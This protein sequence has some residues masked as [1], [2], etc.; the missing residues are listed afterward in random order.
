M[1]DERPAKDQVL[2][3]DEKPQKEQLLK[4]IATS[5]IKFPHIILFNCINSDQGAEGA[6]DMLADFQD[7]LLGFHSYMAGFEFLGL[8]FAIDPSD[9]LGVVTIGI[10]TFAFLLS[11]MGS[12][13]SFI[14]IEYFTG[15][16]NE[17]EEMI[18]QG[19][20]KYWW[21]FYISD[22]V[23]F[24]STLAFIGGVNVLIHI[25]LPAWAAYSFNAATAIAVPVLCFCFKTIILNR[26]VYAGG[27]G[28]FKYRAQ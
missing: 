10:L 15:I 27:R 14:A 24:F 6:L 19:I 1:E 21:F 28:I 23:A 20:L 17:S 8:S 16:K 18:V 22:I 12:M 9:D 7:K 4:Q 25:N 26:Q 5:G 3:E 13:I 2:M 11:A